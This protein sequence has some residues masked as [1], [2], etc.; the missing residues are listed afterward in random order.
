MKYHLSI[1]VQKKDKSVKILWK[2][3]ENITWIN[4]ANE[5]GAVLVIIYQKLQWDEYMTIPVYLRNE[6][7]Y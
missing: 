4:L 5:I 6:K 3:L 2:R 7:Y 1:I